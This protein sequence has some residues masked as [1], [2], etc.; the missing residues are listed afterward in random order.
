MDKSISKLVLVNEY[1]HLNLSDVWSSYGGLSL[2]VE[3]EMDRG[4]I[5]TQVQDRGLHVHI[6]GPSSCLG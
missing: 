6:G 1:S 4:R 2:V 5:R 3:F